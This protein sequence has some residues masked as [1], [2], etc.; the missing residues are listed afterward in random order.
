VKSTRKQK[1]GGSV[2][3]NLHDFALERQAIML[4]TQILRNEMLWNRLQEPSYPTLLPQDYLLLLAALDTG[5]EIRSPVRL[6]QLG[7]QVGDPAY[8]FNLRHKKVSHIVQLA[9][10]VGPVIENFLCEEG[11][12]VQLNDTPYTVNRAVTIC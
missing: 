2:E 8:L 7:D 3:E 1:I 9:I 12:V 6:V 10:P 11:L 4:S 5:W